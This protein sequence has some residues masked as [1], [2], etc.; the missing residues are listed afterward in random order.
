M[1]AGGTEGVPPGVAPGTLLGAVVLDGGGVT[2]VPDGVVGAI[3]GEV[4]GAVEAGGVTGVVPFGFNV[5]GG[6]PL[7]SPSTGGRG[8]VTSRTPG[9]V[10]GVVEGVT[11]AVV[12]EGGDVVGVVDAGGVGAVLCKAGGVVGADGGVGAAFGGV[13]GGGGA[14]GGAGGVTGAAFGATGGGGGATR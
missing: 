6:C 8:G 9:G 11:G 3:D 5:D 4:P 12:D 1:P 13:T 2:G 14:F 10:L 7:R